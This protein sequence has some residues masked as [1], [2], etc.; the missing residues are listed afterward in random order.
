MMVRA[1]MV[2]ILILQSAA[3]FAQTTV[4]SSQPDAR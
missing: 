4:Q 1:L 2:L 3:V